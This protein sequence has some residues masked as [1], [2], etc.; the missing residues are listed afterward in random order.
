LLAD[1]S[2]FQPAAAFCKICDVT[3]VHEVITDS[4]A[5]QKQ[6]AQL[7]DLGLKVTIVDVA[8]DEDE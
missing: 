2:K 4:A 8:R 3:A 5:P 6:L 1:S 7:R